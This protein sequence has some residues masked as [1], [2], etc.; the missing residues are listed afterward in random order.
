[1][2]EPVVPP[3]AVRGPIKARGL[4]LA[5]PPALPPTLGN[6]VDNFAGDT[7]SRVWNDN[8]GSIT[9]AGGFAT[10]PYS[11]VTGDPYNRLGTSNPR[12]IGNGQTLYWEWTFPTAAI[13]GA[14]QYLIA[15]K[16]TPNN[17]ILY[18]RFE[19]SI[20][21][22]VTANGGGAGDGFAPWDDVAHRWLRMRVTQTAIIFET[23]ADGVTWNDPFG[24]DNSIPI[25]FDLSSLVVGFRNGA[26]AGA[27][28]GDIRIHNVNTR[29]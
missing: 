19:T 12:R 17:E 16:D 25:P 9:V 11:G 5:R 20:G 7:L 29:G 8:V 10:L 2:T 3:V 1:M 4:S 6:L 15:Y 21:Y 27:G 24:G 18:G 26:F 28:A 22:I 14:Q 13:A 23:S